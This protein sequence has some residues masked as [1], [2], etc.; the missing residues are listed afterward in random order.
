MQETYDDLEARKNLEGS[1]QPSD[2]EGFSRSHDSKPLS[3]VRVR[4]Y[5]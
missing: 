4:L 1:E 2:T 3:V 5:T